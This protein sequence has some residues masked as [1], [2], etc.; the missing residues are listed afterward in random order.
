MKTNLRTTAAIS[1]EQR[2]AA[3]GAAAGRRGDHKAEHALTR[4]AGL[5]LELRTALGTLETADLNDADSGLLA[6]AAATVV[7]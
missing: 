1:L 2:L 7:S 3:A 5:L 6:E 4:V